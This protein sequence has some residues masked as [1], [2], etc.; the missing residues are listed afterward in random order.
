[1]IT[2]LMQILIQVLINVHL[3]VNELC[4]Y[5]NA[6]CN[7][8]NYFTSFEIYN[9]LVPWKFQCPSERSLKLMS[10]KYSMKLPTHFSVV[11]VGNFCVI[12]SL[13]RNIYEEYF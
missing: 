8:K 2:I 5:Q 6:R 1:M 12:I 4:E 13:F 7:D 3:L 11:K 10:T 9:L